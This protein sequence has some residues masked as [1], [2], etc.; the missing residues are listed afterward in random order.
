MP[1]S[2]VKRP[3]GR[4]TEIVEVTFK[5]LPDGNLSAKLGDVETDTYIDIVSVLCEGNVTVKLEI[6]PAKKVEFANDGA[7]LKYWHGQVIGQ[8]K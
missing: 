5:K 3:K 6:L 8:V 1:K 4:K 7:C 2:K